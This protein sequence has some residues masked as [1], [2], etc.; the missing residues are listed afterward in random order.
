[1]MNH[2]EFEFKSA[3]SCFV[4]SCLVADFMK[5]MIVKNASKPQ[6]LKQGLATFWREWARQL[7]SV[8]RERERERERGGGG[9]GASFRGLEIPTNRS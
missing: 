1:M 9:G 2:L 4:L 7:C 3:Y 8:L 6:Y 5:L